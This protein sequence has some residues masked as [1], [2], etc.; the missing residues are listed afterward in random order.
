MLFADKNWK[1]NYPGCD[2][3]TSVVQNLTRHGKVHQDVKADEMNDYDCGT[4]NAH[5]A[6]E[7]DGQI[8]GQK[9]LKKC[10]N[11][12]RKLV[13]ERFPILKFPQAAAE[14]KANQQEFN[15]SKNRFSLGCNLEI[16][17]LPLQSTEIRRWKVKAVP[18]I[19]WMSKRNRSGPDAFQKL[20]RSVMLF[21]EPVHGLSA[22]RNGK[23]ITRKRTHFK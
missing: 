15:F 1:C 21:L 9:L 8:T 11:G 2:Y 3:K 17:I 16:E 12:G 14:R 13:K 5:M 7:K 19:G 10:V 20:S 23:I 18:S 4:N 6:L 22:I